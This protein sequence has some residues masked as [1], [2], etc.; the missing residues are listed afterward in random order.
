MP[1]YQIA[2]LAGDAAAHEFLLSTSTS[3]TWLD[4]TRASSSGSDE[5]LNAAFDGPA[6]TNS[7]SRFQICRCVSWE[8]SARALS[9]VLLNF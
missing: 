5:G 2:G 1:R 3:R 6:D 4:T 8:M 9:S 7:S